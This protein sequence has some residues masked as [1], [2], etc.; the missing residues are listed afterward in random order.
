MAFQSDV[1][2]YRKY[3]QLIVRRRYLF[4]TTFLLV[5]TAATF[6]NLFL[7]KQYQASS[8]LFIEKGVLNDIVKGLAIPANVDGNVKVLSYTMKSRRLIVKVI[9]DLGLKTSRPEVVAKD[10]QDRTSIAVKDADGLFTISFR[11]SDP[12]LAQNYVNTLIKRYVREYLS[13]QRED[14]KGATTFLADQIGIYKTKLDAAEAQLNRFRQENGSSLAETPTQLQLEIDRLQQSVEEISL[15]RNQLEAM[16]LLVRKTEDP[17][18]AKLY[19]LQRKL[20]E[21]TSRF[22]D[23]YP[24]VVALREEMATV[25]QQLQRGPRMVAQADSSEEARLLAE[26]RGLDEMERSYRQSILAKKALQKGLPEILT[27]LDELERSRNAQKNLYEQFVTRYEQSEVSRQSEVQAKTVTFRIVDPAVVPSKP[28]S[29]KPDKILL[30]GFVGGVLA[31]LALI[32]SL[33]YLDTSVRSPEAFR[34][35][36]IP[37]LAIVQK[38]SDPGQEQASRKR[39]VFFFTASSG[40]LLM[41]LTTFYPGLTALFR[42][43]Q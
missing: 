42:I 7:P 19:E 41:L 24:E 3:L 28:F 14:T 10:F 39:D 32:L 29:P 12:N 9:N 16:R 43:M 21:M 15:K 6:A 18:Q 25:R 31:G 17:L 36:G 11:H 40:Y 35:L 20:V 38:V 1:P 2:D 33:D 5:M 30:L 37:V 22:T 4:V 26:I 23:S 34:A 13:L 27:A 8:T